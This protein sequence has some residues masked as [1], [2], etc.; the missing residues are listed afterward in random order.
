MQMN[1]QTPPCKRYRLTENM[2][3]E[4]LSCKS[5]AKL[6]PPHV[7]KHSTSQTEDLAPAQDG[8]P[9]PPLIPS[10]LRPEKCAIP[11]RLR[12]WLPKNP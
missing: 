11:D 4:L 10:P 5:K 8:N 3:E 2:S 9:L 6:G 7:L 12:R 1:S